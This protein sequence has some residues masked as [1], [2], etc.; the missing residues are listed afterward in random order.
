VL[1][2]IDHLGN[3]VVAN[4][5]TDANGFYRFAGLRPGVYTLSEIQTVDFTDGLDYAGTLGGTIAN[6][7]V[8]NI[9]IP[10]GSNSDF[11]RYRFTESPLTWI[12]GTVF[13]D[14]NQN[15]KLEAEEEGVEGIVV[16]LTGKTKNGEPVNMTT[17]TNARGYYVFG[18]IEAGTYSVIEGATPG[19][20]DAAEQIGT[21]G[22]RVGA[23]RFE[24]VTVSASKPGDFYNFGEYRPGVIQGQ[25]YIDYDRDGVLDRKDGL[26]A[27][28]T[29]TLNGIN[30]LGE[31]TN[32]SV[33]TDY[34]GK[35]RFENL[36]P[37]MYS[38]QSD[39]Q[40]G[41]DYSVSNVGI[42]NGGARRDTTNGLGSKYGFT[43]IQ[44]PAGAIG[45]GY[46]VG[47]VDPNFDPSILG[48]DFQQV[49]VING[50]KGDDVFKVQ[51]TEEQA[52]ID[53]NGQV[54]TIDN[55]E[56]PS[57]RIMGSF[58]RDW[59]DF[60]GSS[61]KEQIELRQRSARITGTWF[62][63]LIYGMESINF[64]GGGYEDV[65]RFYDSPLNDVFSASPMTAKMVG[66]DYSNSVQGVHR[67]YAYATDGNDSAMLT[68]ASGITDYF[69]AAPDSAKLYGDDFYLYTTDFD[70]AVGIAT[71]VGDRAYLFDS[72]GNDA[73]L[74][75]EN[76]AILS[77]PNYHLTASG[78]KYVQAEA[79]A[80]G[81]DRAT[82]TGTSG[83]DNFTSYPL[84]TTLDANKTRIRARGFENTIV[85]AGNG[86]D[87]ATVFDSQFQDSFTVQ[88][89][90]ALLRNSIG[91]VQ[92]NGFERVTARMEAGGEDTAVI[93]GSSSV[94]TFKSTPDSWSFEG[95]GYAFF[96]VGFTKVTAYGES[97][98]IANL[99][100]TA[101]ND[102][103]ELTQSRA[104]LIG[105]RFQNEANGFGRV[106]VDAQGGFDRIVF[107]DSAIRSN[108]EY[109]GTNATISG[110]GFNY[111]ATGFE[112][113][114][115]YYADIE[116]LDTVD[117][118]GKIE[119]AMMASDIA[120]AKNKLSIRA[121]A[122]ASPIKIQNRVDRL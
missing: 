121:S 15:R 28:V 120:T 25:I 103:L 53:V 24:N 118:T 92:M 73:L 114:D 38:I 98:D 2:G 101:Y 34:K 7:A 52:T 88:P 99:V 54:L 48:E 96:G 17:T 104:T 100:D 23:D 102:V 107:Y 90:S 35:Y 61:N 41:L 10:A 71:D 50:T 46:N 36:R 111:N 4:T 65:A 20:L 119:Y 66:S 63:T 93:R 13:V 21:R 117:L 89:G 87:T 106:N 12:S 39:A 85:S 83:N 112:S 44:L 108:I 69:N 32:E 19:Y 58:G 79:N 78:Y 91:D 1:S 109:D 14:Q 77:G 64:D 67:I 110:T 33:M 29:V 75:G 26:I 47:H 56:L 31:V 116:G 55:K 72:V 6:D 105:Q 94:D 37:G 97:N 40:D 27:N 42:Y 51:M 70:S 60:I 22:G 80:G 81:T 43:A 3:P 9:V 86:R 5:T 68:G 57:I 18:Y 59:I 82:L 49:I 8:S 62:E 30:D 113:I 115:A 74:A 122:T 76:S 84:N 95:S 45:N 16:T 11:G